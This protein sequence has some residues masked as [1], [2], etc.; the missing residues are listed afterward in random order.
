MR[1][2][3]GNITV[4]T[5]LMAMSLTL[6]L[7]LA[8]E[9]GCLYTVKSAF[10]NDLNVAREETLSAGCGM[11]L[12]SSPDPGGLLAEKVVSS[13]RRNG[14]Q[15]GITF[16][17]YEAT[18]EQIERACPQIDDAANVRA[19][20][21]HVVLESAYESTMVPEALLGELNVSNGITA[22]LA[23]YATHR[24]YKPEG[25]AGR[26]W[27][28]SAPTASSALSVQERPLTE[29]TP[30]LEAAVVQALEKPAEIYQA[31]N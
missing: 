24:T 7:A 17:F 20:A 5:A 10:D 28:F 14:Y 11:Q 23:P 15:G 2:E 4:L 13:L 22:A 30:A 8:V 26:L 9:F 12:K 3:G 27:R 18:P 21:Y 19:M 16:W 31:N 6:A 25:I 29:T 1:D